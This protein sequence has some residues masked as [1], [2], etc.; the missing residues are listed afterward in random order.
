MHAGISESQWEPTSYQP[1]RQRYTPQPAGSP[2][3]RSQ[4]P[5]TQY[6]EATLA[7]DEIGDSQSQVQVNAQLLDNAVAG[8]S[9]LR[10]NRHSSVDSE[11]RKQPLEDPAT[12]PSSNSSVVPTPRGSSTVSSPTPRQTPRQ[13]E[14]RIGLGTVGLA[15]RAHDDAFLVD[16]NTG[17][18][19]PSGQRRWMSLGV[20]SDSCGEDE[21]P[22]SPT[23]S[24]RKIPEG[25]LEGVEGYVEFQDPSTRVPDRRQVSG[26]S[27]SVEEYSP[28]KGRRKIPHLHCFKHY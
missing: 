20:V 22:F 26:G 15:G 14:G 19:Y 4:L 24:P 11:T 23:P 7:S 9:S 10:H 17:E 16:D 27:G 12:A 18:V 21:E 13:T 2:S 25:P 5:E 3:Q 28:L 8:L 6:G 1:P